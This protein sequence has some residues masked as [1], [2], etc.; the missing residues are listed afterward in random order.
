V[1]LE[2]KSCSLKRM[3]VVEAW[4]PLKGVVRVVFIASNH[5]IAIAIFLPHTDGP[6]SW[7]GRSAPTRST[8][9][10]QRLV[11]MAL[12]MTIIT[13]NVSSDVR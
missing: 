13:L 11:I 4:M 12:L 6:C 8:T 7:S 10:L 2:V 3:R 1:C 5:L 9:G